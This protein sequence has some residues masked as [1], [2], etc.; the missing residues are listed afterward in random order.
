MLPDCGQ[1]LV[2]KVVG[3]QCQQGAAQ[4]GQIGQEVGV[5]AARAVFSHKRITPPMIADLHSAPVSANE[6]EPR[7]GAVLVRCGAGEVVMGLGGGLAGSFDGAAVAQD[8]QGSGK[9]EIGCERFDGKGVQTPDFDP[10]VSGMG[11]DKKGV[12][13]RLSKA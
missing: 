9:G 1:G 2:W 12:S 13:L 11:I 4:D 10:S 3:E 6:L 7:C 8:N 5:A